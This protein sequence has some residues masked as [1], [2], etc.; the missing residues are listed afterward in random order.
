MH[1]A[2]KDVDAGAIMFIVIFFSTG[3]TVGYLIKNALHFTYQIPASVK[4]LLKTV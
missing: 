4:L 1:F 3:D 2:I